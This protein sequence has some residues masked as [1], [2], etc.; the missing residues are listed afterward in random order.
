MLPAE[1]TSSGSAHPG[2][3]VGA[4]LPSASS[5]PLLWANVYLSHKSYLCVP[6]EAL[7]ASSV[8][9]ALPPTSVWAGC[10][11]QRFRPPLCGVLSWVPSPPRTAVIWPLEWLSLPPRES[12]QV[13][14]KAPTHHFLP[15]A[16]TLLGPE[17]F[18]RTKGQL[19]CSKK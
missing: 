3:S 16:G 6:E 10:P 13:Q 15:G 11:P 14:A 7:P 4:C 8:S 5:V 2:L 17:C 9:P 18:E 12:V 1:V 19:K